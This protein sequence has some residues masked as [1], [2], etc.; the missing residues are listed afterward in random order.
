MSPIIAR[1]KQGA[2]RPAP[3]GLFNA[4]CVDVR[5]LGLK[6]TPSGERY[7]VEVRW[8]ISEIDPVSQKPYLATQW[9]TLSLHEMASLRNTVEVL[10]DRKLSDAEAI[11]GI[12]LE[13]LVGKCCQI[14]IVHNRTAKGGVFANVKTCVPLS[15]SMTRL[16][17]R[18]YVR[19]SERPE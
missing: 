6:P 17:S 4:V 1:A 19:V 2:F 3:E 10:L 11:E 5:D 14:Q 15:R 7:K 12:D 9:Y 18:D 13:T 16:T 8:Q